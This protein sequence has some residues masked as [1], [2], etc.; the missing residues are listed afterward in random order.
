MHIGNDY[1]F[2]YLLCRIRTEIQRIRGGSGKI[3]EIESVDQG[4]EGIVQINDGDQY[5][6]WK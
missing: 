4:G 6:E 3:A 1:L 5:I 2:I